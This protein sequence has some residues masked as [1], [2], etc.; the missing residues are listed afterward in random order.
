MSI[1]TVVRQAAALCQQTVPTSVMAST[2]PNVQ[3]LLAFAQ[4]EGDELAEEYDWRNL[5][6]ACQIYGDGTTTQFFLAADFDR[7][8]IVNPLWSSAYPLTPLPG[9][10][11]DDEMLALRA[12]NGLGLTPVWRLLGGAV[13]FYPA[14]GASEVVTGTYISSSWVLAADNSTR[15]GTF[16]ADTDQ[17][18][19]P[20]SLIVLGAVWRWKSSK[21]LEYA[22]DFRSS[23]ERRQLMAAHDRGSRPILMSR[24]RLPDADNWFPGTITPIGPTVS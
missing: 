19:I 8:P 21:G 5:K 20:E 22:E 2:D 14:L 16:Q 18:L 7:F 4:Q 24:S 12:R 15:Y 1:L 3:Q 23:Q 6:V 9:P 10:M 11:A 13:E 17:C